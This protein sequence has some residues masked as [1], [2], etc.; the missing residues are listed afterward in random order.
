MSVHSTKEYQDKI[1]NLFNLFHL[2]KFLDAEDKVK[3]LIKTYGRVVA[4]D[5]A[6]LE[7]YPGEVLAIVGD[8][9]AGKSTLIKCIT[10]AEKADSGKII[11]DGAEVSFN[12]VQESR[13][14]GIETVYQSLAVAP[15]LDVTANIFL[16]REIRRR[17]IFGQLSRMMDSSL[18][19]KD[20]QK[21]ISSLGIET[22]QNIN[23][24]VETLSG[25]QRQAVAVARAVAFS[26]K[27]IILDEPTAA[28]GVRESSQVLNLIKNLQSRGLPVI[29]ISH[30]MPQVFEVANRIQIQRL[31]KRAGV[32]T[33]KTHDM[34]DVVAVMTGA[35]KLEQKD[36]TL[37]S[38]T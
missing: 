10:G 13:L 16:G 25:G 28:L 4:L 21:Y 34:K 14:A 22:I 26:Q 8:N 29:I 37:N 7:L 15:S 20:A 6:D 9:G 32:V 36:Q 19:K 33:P 1:Q 38:V 5:G 27:I 2:K 30:N 18:M 24:A 11:L 23:Q 3:N 17:G 12:K 31:G 35:L